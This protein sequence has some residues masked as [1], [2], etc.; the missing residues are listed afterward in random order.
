[1]NAEVRTVSCVGDQS[2]WSICQVHGGPVATWLGSPWLCAR[3]ARARAGICN[4]TLRTVAREPLGLQFTLLPSDLRGCS[5]ASWGHFTDSPVT[6]ERGS[7][8]QDA[9]KLSCSQ[10]VRC[11]LP[12]EG[13]CM[14]DTQCHLGSCSK[15]TPLQPG[16]A[17]VAAVGCC[18]T[19]TGL[20][21]RS[22]QPRLCWLLPCLRL[23]I[24]TQSRHATGWSEQ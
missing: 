4:W 21:G 13:P 3:A 5:K 16:L 7:R 14:Q 12:A 15:D 19:D 17:R 6:R 1:M 22:C 10:E 24:C 2:P 9:Q 23:A 18:C 8:D 20:K 11:Q